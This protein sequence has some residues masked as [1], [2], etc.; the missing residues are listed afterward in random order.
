MLAVGLLTA[1][2]FVLVSAVTWRLHSKH[3]N[4]EV[5]RHAALLSETMLLSLRDAMHANR[6]N[7]VDS[8]VT[9]IQT[10]PGIDR[11]RIFDKSGQVVVSTDESEVGTTVPLSNEQCIVCHVE[12]TPKVVL[13][14]PERT[15]TFDNGGESPFLGMITPIRN[16]PDCS[17]A[18][19]HA[20]P[21]DKEILGVL[22]VNLSLVQTH[23]SLADEA[24]KFTI[25][26]ILGCLLMVAAT[27]ISVWHLVYRPIHDITIGT[28]ELSAGNLDYRLPEQETDEFNGLVQSFNAMTADLRSAR[29][30]VHEWNRLLEDRVAEKTAE[31]E[32]TQERMIQTEKM[33]SLGKLAAVVAHEI[34]N[35]LAGILTYIKLLR[36]MIK[37]RGQEFDT[38]QADDYLGMAEGE[39]IRVG[40]IVKNLLAFSRPSS[41]ERQ[42]A[43]INAIIER[44]MQ[45]IRHQ[46]NLQNV[47]Q[48]TDTDKNAPKVKADPNH[49]Q[50]A[51]LAILINAVE[52]MPEG[53]R[54]QVS[55][56]YDAETDTVRIHVSDTGIGVPDEAIPHLFEPFYTT[57]TEGKG[58]GLGLFVVYG[59]IKR[60][61]GTIDVKSVINEG[62]TF[63]ITLPVEGF[64]EEGA[65]SSGSLAKNE[66]PEES[67]S[68]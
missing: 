55:S 14:N 45:L 32:E 65:Q 28:R 39:T 33:A 63:I 62:T 26:S 57:K 60:H 22:D 53:G 67:P 59:I 15:Y 13:A 40:N 31:L 4:D 3:L 6:F 37:K 30:E 29:D 18:P 17:N 61:G 21:P 27:G 42:E 54:V 35:P 52:A 43:D 47:E 36:R 64:T 7:V 16:E 46:M 20:H 19:C 34:N 41:P 2:L 5:V 10:Q 48:V 23:N 1:L 11:I 9:R 25:V 49:I 24:R 8:M 56:R 38:D 51:L 58:V 50:Q 66:S 68:A 12:G 44:S